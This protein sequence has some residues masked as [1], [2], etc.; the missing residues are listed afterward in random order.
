MFNVFSEYQISS[1]RR[2][3]TAG[4]AA[5]GAVFATVSSVAAY[6]IASAL[7]GM[8]M[9]RRMTLAMSISTSGWMYI[10]ASPVSRSSVIELRR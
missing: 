6:R 7:A 4:V 3:F 1:I 2:R 8:A 5:D 10:S 9:N